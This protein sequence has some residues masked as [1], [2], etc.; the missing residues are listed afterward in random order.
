M[1][2]PKDKLEKVEVLLNS[3]IS[4]DAKIKFRDFYALNCDFDENIIFLATRCK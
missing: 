2:E 1:N 3:G 4:S